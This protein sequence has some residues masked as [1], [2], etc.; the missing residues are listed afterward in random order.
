MCEYGVLPGMYKT[1][2]LVPINLHNSPQL[3]DLYNELD[4][5]EP[6]AET[7]LDYQLIDDSRWPSVTVQ[8]AWERHERKK[9][10]VTVN[11]RRPRETQ[12]RRAAVATETALIC[13]L[14]NGRA[15][16]GLS[17]ITD[18]PALPRL[19]PS[20]APYSTRVTG[21]NRT[22]TRV[23]GKYSWPP[24]TVEWVAVSYFSRWPGSRPHLDA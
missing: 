22:F 9:Q 15:A 1:N 6:A 4:S 18:Q 23:E 12:D 2:Q 20:T 3:L 21:H 11:N 10:P 13:A 14:T 24:G 19:P 8:S 5:G 7:S 16:P 17:S